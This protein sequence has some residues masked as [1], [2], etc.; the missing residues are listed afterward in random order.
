MKKK[1]E[2]QQEISFLEQQYDTL[3][4]LKKDA[5]NEFTFNFLR[6]EMN[7]VQAKI[8]ALNWVVRQG[9]RPHCHD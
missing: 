7:Q 2:I 5:K 8:Q 1:V 4:A 9:K 3:S 6:C